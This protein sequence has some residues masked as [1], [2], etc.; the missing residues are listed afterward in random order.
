M[1]TRAA[2]ALDE[3]VIRFMERRSR[4]AAPRRTPRDARELLVGLAKHYGEGTL[5]VPSPF[6]PEP[7]R[8]R[9]ERTRA[10]TGPHGAAVWDLRFPSEY[11]P[12]L[13]AYRDEHQRHRE[14]LT[15]HA[16]LWTR[17]RGRSAV[18]LLHG[19]GGGAYWVSERSFAV[20]YWLR[21]GLDVVA[22]QLPLHGQRTP[23]KARSGQL[24][25]SP[26]VVRTN[27]AFGQAIHDLR[28]LADEL[29]ASG[30]PAVGVMGMSLGGY[31]TALWAS[32][33]DQLAFAVAMI[34]AVSMAELMWRHG[35]DSPSRRRAASAGVSRELLAEVFAVHTPT[36]RAPRIARDRLTIIAGKGDRITPPEQAERLHAHWGGDLHWFAGGH[37]AQVGRADA[38]R[39]VRRKLDDLGLTRRDD[40]TTP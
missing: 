28:A 8:A 20:E 18:I 17:G 38:L 10:G 6:F 33:D 39:A 2:A 11:R 5:G 4:P 30:A 22:F 3:S 24:F 25:L 40:R 21:H 13:A 14:N 37:L 29:R 36:T 34:P 1:L 16:R 19:W 15:A 32:I 27:E 26:H 35:E 12:Y 9:V 31:T 7:A 23:A